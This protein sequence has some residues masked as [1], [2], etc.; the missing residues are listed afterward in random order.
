MKTFLWIVFI[1]FAIIIG[2]YPFLYFLVDMGPGFLS[3]KPDV[4]RQSS[5]W[6]AAFYQH[7]LF[8]AIAMLTG[9]SQF[10]KHLRN[11]N[12]SIHRTLG[13]IY[14][15]A[16]I[17]SGL[18]GLYLAMFA[19][20]GLISILGFSGLAIGWLFSSSMAYAMIRKKNIEEHQYWMI[21]SYALCWAAVTL[22]IWL[23][24]LQIGF[25]MDFNTAYKIISWLCWVPNIVVAE[26]IIR[27]LK[28]VRGRSSPLL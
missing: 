23:P 9:W 6:N 19:N 24:G 27:N 3:S 11:K 7:I 8:G 10:S 26:I 14:L 5:I 13:K 16:V 1:F 4:L 22:R 12:L 2:I 15:G 17:L 25:G 21:R 20:G 18:A 28:N